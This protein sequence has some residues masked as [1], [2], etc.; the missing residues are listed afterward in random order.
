MNLPVEGVGQ[1]TLSDDESTLLIKDMREKI[2]YM[3]KI[4]PALTPA[5]LQTSI[6]TA[7]SPNLWRPVLYQLIEEGVIKTATVATVSPKNR[8]ESRELW[9]LA[10]YPYALVDPTIAAGY[11]TPTSQVEQTQTPEPV[12][13]ATLEATSPYPQV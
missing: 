13:P 2:L 3:L 12:S 11:I 5:C 4:M 10:D 9:H 7:V 8:H 6:G 1:A